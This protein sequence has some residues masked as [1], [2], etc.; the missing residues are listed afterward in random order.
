[1][2]LHRWGILLALCVVVGVPTFVLKF[3]PAP[4]IETNNGTMRMWWPVTRG[5]SYVDLLL[6]IFS[7]VIQVSRSVVFSHYHKYMYHCVCICALTHVHVSSDATLGA[8]HDVQIKKYSITTL[9]SGCYDHRALLSLLL[10]LDVPLQS[11]IYLL[12]VTDLQ[13]SCTR[14]HIYM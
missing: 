8:D 13:I 6:F 5:L 4:K 2:L 9:L 10:Y 7:S 11:V 12:Y 14:I 3:T 1:M